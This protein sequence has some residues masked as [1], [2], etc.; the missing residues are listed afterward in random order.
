MRKIPLILQIFMGF[1]L[2]TLG[3][4][5]LSEWGSPQL[6]E[7][8]TGIVSPFGNLLVA[9]LKMV[10]FPM[11]L[12]S[13]IHGAA[14]LPLRKSGK[15]GGW[16]MVWYFATSLF[17]TFFGVALAS[18]LNPSIEAGATITTGT[19][20]AQAFID[21]S[22]AGATSFATFIV[23]IFQNPFAALAQGEF[24]AIVVFAIAFGLAARCL[25]D[26]AS[27]VSATVQKLIDVVDAIQRI[28]FRLTE[29]VIRY[30]PF[31]VFALCLVNFT[32]NGV[33]LFGPYLRIIL[34]VVMGV[35]L[36]IFV[37]YPLAL[38]C[39]CR[40]NP[41]RILYRIRMAMLTAFVTR[42]SAATLPLS[43]KAMDGLRVNKALSSFSL[44]MGATVNMDGV[45]IHL[46]VF[47]ILAANLFGLQLSMVE[48]T[49]L[50]LTILLASIGAGGIPGGSVFL[51]FMVLES[52][53]LQADQV[54]LIVTLALGIN[55]ILDMF[56]TCCNV[57]GDNVCTY[58]V[59]KNNH[60]IEES[61]CE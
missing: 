44:P 9:M 50:C 14:S 36:M 39:F 21:S 53:G 1:V 4:L 60:M 56:E 37:I 52:M 6:K 24:L 20:D 35:L 47:V 59:A 43:F 23:D 51:L 33:L 15:V 55:P 27:S 16:V 42:S 3:G 11:I 30:F 29:W 2:G 8:I 7:N 45:C 19:A 18:F 25:I 57:T 40:E 34:C 49:T 26:E 46:P 38:F 31:G 58:I 13:L 22:T 32:Q 17:A 5:F 41:F 48:I 12:F 28:M 54:T 61:Q 10:V